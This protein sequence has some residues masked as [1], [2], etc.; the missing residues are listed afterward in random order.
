MVIM[1]SQYGY[2]DLGLINY[3]F[4]RVF[5]PD[6]EIGHVMDPAKA[7]QAFTFIT[8]SLAM[9]REGQAF[10]EDDF[11]RLLKT[12]PD[13][14]DFVRSSPIPFCSPSCGILDMKIF[15]D[16][17]EI[18][19]DSDFAQ[20]FKTI[21]LDQASGIPSLRNEELVSR[22][23]EP[24]PDGLVLGV[25][26]EE[27]FRDLLYLNANAGTADMM[28]VS[29]GTIGFVESMDRDTDSTNTGPYPVIGS[30]EEIIQMRR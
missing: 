16:A 26:A 22:T 2:D 12:F 20:I 7:S 28:I 21:G 19:L 9:A 18:V 6:L 5:A 1:K 25:P 4:Y 3:Y 24:L 27:H 14:E 13:L 11:R 10:P 8:G 29:R 15:S 23:D 30:P 17:F